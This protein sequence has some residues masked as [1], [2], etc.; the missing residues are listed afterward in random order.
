MASN[1]GS[2]DEPCKYTGKEADTSGLYFYESRYYDSVLGR[3]ALPDA[4]AP[5][6][7]DSQSLNRY[8]YALNNP[9]TM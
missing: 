6:M 8:A 1:D 4:I 2:I 9:V 5:G 7:T 3:Y